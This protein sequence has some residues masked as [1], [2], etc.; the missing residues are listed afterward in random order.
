MAEPAQG[1]A[2]RRSFPPYPSDR[3][4]LCRRAAAAAAGRRTRSDRKSRA[5]RAR[6]RQ[7]G[8]RAREHAG[9]AVD[10]YRPAIDH[11]RRNRAQSPPHAERRPLRRRGRWRLHHRRW[12]EAADG[13]RRSHSDTVIAVA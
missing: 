2:A 4:A 8:P 7:S 10:L 6:P 13:T 9:D 5:P 3:L 11:A 1:A 12:R